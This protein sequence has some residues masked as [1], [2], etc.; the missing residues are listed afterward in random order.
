MRPDSLTQ[1]G[2]RDRFAAARFT[3]VL[4]TWALTVATLMKSSLAMSALDLPCPTAT[5]TS[6]SR[7][8]RLASLAA[9]EHAR[10]ESEPA[11]GVSTT[12]R[13]SCVG[14]LGHRLG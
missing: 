8:L 3:R 12:L 2:T 10:A 13:M 5:A 7:S 1:K 14:T 9:A 4:E 6:C 11:D